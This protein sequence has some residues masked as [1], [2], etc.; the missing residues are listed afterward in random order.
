MGTDD[1]R[2]ADLQQRVD[3]LQEDMGFLR[4]LL[5]HLGQEFARFKEKK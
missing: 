2:V 3:K 5:E 1:E 4:Q